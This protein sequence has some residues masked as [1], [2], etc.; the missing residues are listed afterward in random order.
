MCF[1]D[2]GCFEISQRNLFFVSPVSLGGAG[3]TAFQSINDCIVIFNAFSKYILSGS[4]LC[5]SQIFTFMIIVTTS[6]QVLVLPFA[7]L[8]RKKVFVLEERKPHKRTSS[9]EVHQL[10]SSSTLAERSPFEPTTQIDNNRQGS[11]CLLACCVSFHAHNG[12]GGACFVCSVQ[13][14][15]NVSYPETNKPKR[16]N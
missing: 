11:H 13:R 14:L 16:K 1:T 5:C 3:R 7:Y 9:N 6:Y 12:R 10:W 8:Y 4:S 2:V 15:C